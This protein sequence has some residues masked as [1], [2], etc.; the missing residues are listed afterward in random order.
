[1]GDGDPHLRSVA[2]RLAKKFRRRHSNDREDALSQIRSI[3]DRCADLL[4]DYSGVA[5]ELPLPE[6]IADHGFR[7][8][9]V[10][11]NVRKGPA[12]KGLD[13]EDGEVVHRDLARPHLLELPSGA[14]ERETA[15]SL[16]ARRDHS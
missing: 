13:A 9:S 14:G 15:A 3:A 11:G 5:A 4:A 10:F 6:A 1:M 16:A 2:H 7:H 8:G 12:E